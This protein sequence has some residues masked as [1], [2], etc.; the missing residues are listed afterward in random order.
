MQD[1]VSVGLSRAIKIGFWAILL[2]IAGLALALRAGLADPKP[3]GKQLQVDEFTD[4]SGWTWIADSGVTYEQVPGGL[5]INFPDSGKVALA[6]GAAP[7]LPFTLEVAGA[8]SSGPAGLAYGLVFGYESAADYTVVWLNNNGYAEALSLTDGSASEW[9][10]WQ[11]WP[12]ILSGQEAN[13]VRV[14]VEAGGIVTARINDEMLVRWVAFAVPDGRAGLAVR[15]Q[16]P[17]TAI[18]SWLKVWSDRR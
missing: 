4:L 6:L 5:R 9:F 14:D 18:F 17:G 2:G 15:S 16:A 7:S 11:Q 13:R 12:H 10:P 3:L 8:Q 1:E